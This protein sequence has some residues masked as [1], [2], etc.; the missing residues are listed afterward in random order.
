MSRDS[1]AV[2]APA[3]VKIEKTPQRGQAFSSEVDTGS[4]DEN[5]SE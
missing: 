2:K 1:L 5:A 3:N 4:R